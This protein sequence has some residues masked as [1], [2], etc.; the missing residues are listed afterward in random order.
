MAHTHTKLLDCLF[1]VAPL[2]Y[3]SHILFFHFDHFV[4]SDFLFLSITAMTGEHDRL[5]SY[6]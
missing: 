2:T 6:P 4:S 5:L 1:I 3:I